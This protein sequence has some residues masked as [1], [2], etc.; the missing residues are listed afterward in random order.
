M[1]KLTMK[2]IFTAAVLLFYITG[3]AY[4]ENISILCTDEKRSKEEGREVVL[5]INFDE[6]GDWIEFGN[7]R[8]IKGTKSTDGKITQITDLEINTNEI[9]ILHDDTRLKIYFLMT[10]NRLNGDMY[11]FVKMSNLEFK[12]NYKCEKDAR[13]F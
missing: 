2:K 9:K 7:K 8:Y 10:I 13:K 5:T 11:Q 4:A 1:F 6:N 3:Y 12:H